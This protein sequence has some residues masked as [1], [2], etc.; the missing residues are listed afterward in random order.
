MID[1]N[2]F[3]DIEYYSEDID[4]ENDFSSYIDFINNFNNNINSSFFNSSIQDNFFSFQKNSNNKIQD[5]NN[6]IRAINN[7]YIYFGGGKSKKWNT[8]THNGVMFPDEYKKHNIPIIYNGKKIFLNKLAEEYATYYSKYINT[9]YINNKTFNKNFWNDWNKTL[10]SDYGITSLS[11]C[12][13]SLIHDHIIKEKEYKLTLS[14]EDKRLIKKKKENDEEK[15]KYAYVDGKKEKIA[16]FKIEPPGIF[17]GRGCHPKTGCIKKRIHPNDVIINID[18]NTKIPSPPYGEW[19]N[20]VHDKTAVWIA[21]FFD[22][23]TKKNKYVYLSHESYFKASSDKEKFDLARKLK[24]K[25]NSIRQK[26]YSLLYS[27]SYVVKQLASALYFID[28]FALRIGSEKSYEAADTVGATNLKVKNIKLL[29]N[30]TIELDFLGKDSIR[31]KNKHQVDSLIYQNIKIFI[32]NKNKNDKIFDSI[33]S[34][35]LNKYLNSYMNSL[36]GKVF[37]TFNSSYIFQKEINK[38]SKAINNNKYGNLD[39]PN[40]DQITSISN[41]ILKANLKVSKLCNHQK[42]VSKNLSNQIEKFNDKIKKY[43]T[44][45]KLLQDKKS[46]LSTSKNDKNKARKFNDRIL[47]LKNLIINTRAKRNLKFEMKNN[48]L[49]TSKS[50]YIDPRIIFSFSKKHNLNSLIDKFY[51]ES[52]KKKFSWAS[53]VSPDFNF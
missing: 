40:N 47:K 43:K 49:E 19:K 51:S 20:V 17:L 22:P 41:D 31:Y 15:Y 21:S 3:N 35:D 7:N 48:T 11:D 52:Q 27:Y 6:N 30:D 25:I 46:N 33:S 45:F 39:N 37:R 24:K 34:T 10:Y 23:I 2:K 28:N 50:N 8:L 38:I 5:Y 29:N 16:N 12:D 13:F 1:S 32:N 42:N 26:N 36:T 18:K 44:K 9:D 53:V 14:K 4:S